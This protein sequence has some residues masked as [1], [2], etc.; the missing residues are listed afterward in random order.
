[1]RRARACL[2]SLILPLI[3][4]AAAQ[5]SPGGGRRAS[6]V[7][8]GVIGRVTDP[9]GHPMAGVLVVALQRETRRGR[10][11]LV[12]VSRPVAVTTNSR[13]QYRLFSSYLGETYVVAFPRGRPPGTSGP[14][15]RSGFGITYYPSADRLESARSVEVAPN[16]AA[17]ADIVMRPARLSVIAGGVIGS[18]GRPINGGALAIAHGDG[19]FG[20]DSS[21]API[22]QDG[23]FETPPMPPGTYHLHYREGLWPPPVTVV[24]KVSTATVSVGTEDVRD[25]KVT[26]VQMVRA[27]GRLVVAPAVRAALPVGTIDVA[28]APSTGDGVPGPQ[29]PGTVKPD[30]SFEFWTWP[31]EGY[32]RV[33]FLSPGWMVRAVR[34]HG[35]DV[36]DK[37]IP[38]RGSMSGLQ[39]E[40]IKAR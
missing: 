31:G 40:V 34:L 21:V 3:A 2:V 8:H 15:D 7:P 17:S 11:P 23:R 12:P 16:G 29:R 5:E 14:Q 13:G 22:G 38:F 20:L 4:T 24:P 32:I 10:T 19:L 39:I 6:T 27:T 35:V 30:L 33:L 18:D 37:D 25:V 1:M 28:A 36:T 26:P 9:A